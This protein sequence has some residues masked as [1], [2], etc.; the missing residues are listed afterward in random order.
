MAQIILN[1]AVAILIAAA[2]LASS[3]TALVSREGEMQKIPV[4]AKQRSRQ[5]R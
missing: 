1:S 3:A 5:D 2:F 4:K